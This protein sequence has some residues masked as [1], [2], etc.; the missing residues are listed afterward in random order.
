MGVVYTRY[1]RGKGSSLTE[2]WPGS[3][4]YGTCR[5]HIGLLRTWTRHLLLTPTSQSRCL[6]HLSSRYMQHLSAETLP[7]AYPKLFTPCKHDAPLLH[8]QALGLS[9]HD[10]ILQFTNARLGARYAC[11]RGASLIFRIV[12]TQFLLQCHS[13]SSR[14]T[15]RIPLILPND[16]LQPTLDAQH[17]AH[18]TF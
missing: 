7:S 5:L 13:I 3:S 6:G 10:R 12:T 9:G 4:V 2:T 16:R 1:G 11:N 14:P 18:G 15:P 8:W 17:L